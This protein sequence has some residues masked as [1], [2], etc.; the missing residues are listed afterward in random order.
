[1]LMTGCA[2]T[3]APVTSIHQDARVAVFLENVSDKSFRAAH[4][5]TLDQDTVANA[6][7]GVHVEKKE[8]IKLLIGK[9]LKNYAPDSTRAFSEDDIEALT[10]HITA[11]LAQA[12]PNQHIKFQLRYAPALSAASRKS[13]A[14]RAET[15]AGYLYA[16]GLSLILTLTE[17]GPGKVYN[18]DTKKEPR[19][20]PDPIGLYDREVKFIPEAAMRPKN[21]D[22]LNWFAGSDAH[23]VAIDYQLMTKL[24]AAPPPPAP[25]ATPGT[26]QPAPTATPPAAASDAELQAFKEQLKALQKKL[27][28]Q[29]AELQELKKSS[30]KKK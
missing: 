22:G 13:G 7:R 16:D 2:G 17:F 8:E 5:I 28:E 9:A 19:E 12:A 10:P 30:I 3:P 4:P 26:A 24:L 29:N 1:M 27:E 20:L 21:S 15:T 18:P 25:A 11:A 14:P 23:T 6:L